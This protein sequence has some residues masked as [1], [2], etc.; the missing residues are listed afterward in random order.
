MGRNKTKTDTKSDCDLK[1]MAGR[2]RAE[3]LRCTGLSKY[4]A[5]FPVLKSVDF[6]V[7]AGEILGI[8]GPNGA[9]KTT[10]MECLAGLLPYDQVIG[11]IVFCRQ[12][13][14]VEKNRLQ[15]PPVVLRKGEFHPVDRT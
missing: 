13:R 15:F 4:F 3:I 7:Y 11:P 2:E 9:G 6:S 8:I 10:L 12:Q 1:V 5:R 14:S